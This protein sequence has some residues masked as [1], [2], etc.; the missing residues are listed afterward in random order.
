[1]HR[2]LALFTEIAL[3]KKKD[4]K[5]TKVIATLIFLSLILHLIKNSQNVTFPNKSIIKSESHKKMGVTSQ[6]YHRNNVFI[7]GLK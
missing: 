5:R 3:E 7:D 1:M 6:R 2:S 4:I